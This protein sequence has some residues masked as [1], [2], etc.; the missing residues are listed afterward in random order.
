[1]MDWD[2]LLSGERLGDLLGREKPKGKPPGPAF[3]DGQF[4]LPQERDHDRILFSTPFRRMGDK[5]QVFP[6][7]SIESIRTRLTHSYEV[8]NLARSLGLE[9]A[10]TLSDRLPAHAIRVLPAT[11]AAVGLAHD[12]GNPPFGHQGEFAI[13]AWFKRNKDV[14]FVP[15]TEPENS[16]V[17]ADVNLL[18][19]QHKNDF[20]F[21]EGNAQ[22]LRVLTKLQVIGDD[23]GLNLSVGTLAAVMKYVA[24][25]DTL[26]KSKQARKKVGYFT[27]ERYAV[28]RIRE[29]T[30][31]SG[32]SRHPLALVMEACDDIAYS[33]L[34]AEDAIKKGLVSLND[35]LAALE[36]HPD[37]EDKL[38]A[39]TKHLC[40]L[41]RWELDFLRRQQ[42]HPSE[43]QDVATQKF[44]VHA[45]HLMVSA[46]AEAFRENYESII[47]GSFDDEL[48]KKSEAAKL[49]SALKKFDRE[50][51][52]SHKSVLEIELNGYNVLNR[53]M[54]FLW[55]G[56]SQRKSFQ[57]LASDRT[58]PF[59]AYVYSRI[60][61]NY[62]RMFEGK[63]EKYHP[64]PRLPIRYKEMQLLTDMVSGM[65]DQFCIDLYRDFEQHY[66]EIRR[67]DGTPA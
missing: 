36:Y 8:A 24:S 11:L 29:E 18:E 61:K 37:G 27:S 41:A 65:T 60:S 22:T 1:M 53:L 20:L 56:I 50:N 33:V 57:D 5:T 62:R 40:E 58:T 39:V 38:D 10:H 59:A 17:A 25:S 47:S 32:N 42:L 21:F 9:I 26:D 34:D 54:D 3:A 13:R 14:L 16:E 67:V 12:I 23:L 2:R 66:R 31:L 49:C 6:L 19:D 64:D 55:V 51:A 45:I 63:V 15:P 30:G 46:V 35:L 44:R 52:F 4:R 43:L 28:E 7:E 48:I